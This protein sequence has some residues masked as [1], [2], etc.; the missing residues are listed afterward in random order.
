MTILGFVG[1]SILLPAQ[2][3]AL[4]GGIKGWIE[5]SLGWYY[6]LLLS[7][8]V[9][10]VIYLL[11]SRWGNVRL[12]KDDSRPEFSNFTW[13][14]MLFGCGTGIGLLFFGV[15]EPIWHYQGNPFVSEAHQ[16]AVAAGAASTEAV[17]AARVSLRL[18]LFHW[19]LHGWAVYAVIGLALAYFSFR[20]NLPLTIRSA[21]YPI[22]GER[23]YGPIG[24]VA[25]IMAVFG[26]IFGLST[27][28]GMGASQ[29][30]TGLE[31]LFGME[32]STGNQIL[33]ILLV[34]AMAT[35]S[36]VTGLARGVKILSLLNSWLCIGILGFILLMGP[37]VYILGSFITGVGDYLQ[38]V[39]PLGMWNGST[40]AQRSWQGGWTIF[41]WGWW[42][43]WGPFV[44]MFIARIS[45]GR[46]IREYLLG[47]LIVP[48]L[49]TF[50]FLSV[51][52][53]AGLYYEIFTD[54]SMISMVNA[55]FAK[56]FFDLLSMMSDS[57]LLSAMILVTVVV[58]MVF[59]VTSSDSGTLVI[60][61][62]LSFG[63]EDPPKRQRIFWG[64]TIGAV[65]GALLFTGGTV[66]LKAVQAASIV[67][68]LPFSFILMALC[69]GLLQSL[70]REPATPAV[71]LAVGESRSE[72]G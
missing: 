39:I 68:A 12:G 69:W 48:T 51:L 5:S 19:G 28:L 26:T 71:A 70:R 27:T 64:M 67:A 62:L 56:A 32:K 58:L 63:N 46:T 66:A 47:V 38:Q 49:V 30:N 60:C 53:A 52:G 44:G 11:C 36:A 31:V 42:I 9:F 40:E 7:A 43:A 29:I 1:Y 21:L 15:A 72:P 37:T 17:D 65:A 61:T 13:F 16:A 50:V 3:K 45:R 25:D 14:S 23:I 35:I 33:I 20:K 41:Y 8:I 24:H 18:T 54:A 59:F 22:F 10:F 57:G 55:D 4:F 2:A 34:S 6:I